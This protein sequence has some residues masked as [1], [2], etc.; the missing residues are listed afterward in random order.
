MPLPILTVRG[1]GPV[2]TQ[3]VPGFKDIKDQRD[4]KDLLTPV[5]LVPLVLYVLSVVSG[6]EKPRTCDGPGVAGFELAY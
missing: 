1:A 5:P 2:M 6:N 3:S 4:Q